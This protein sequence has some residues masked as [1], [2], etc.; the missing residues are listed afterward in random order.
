LVV[1]VQ[2]PGLITAPALRKALGS[3]VGE[4]AWI[5]PDFPAMAR[6]DRPC[7]CRLEIGFPAWIY[8][9]ASM[10]RL[11]SALLR[12]HRSPGPDRPGSVTLHWIG[13]RT[14]IRN[15][16]P[17]VLTSGRISGVA[18]FSAVVGNTMLTA[19]ACAGPRL[20]R[21]GGGFAAVRSIA[22]WQREGGDDLISGVGDLDV[23]AEGLAR[24]VRSRR[25]L[26]CPWTVTRVM[27]WLP[28]SLIATEVG[29]AALIR[30]TTR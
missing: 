17:P 27:R 16:S 12:P 29:P 8:T 28:S 15:C 2:R 1:C 23:A 26:G 14:A 6:V 13:G 20:L 25:S 19:S 3:E 18:R 21:R 30:A 10:R 24:S 9:R 4:R 22:G 7:C 11:R 5:V